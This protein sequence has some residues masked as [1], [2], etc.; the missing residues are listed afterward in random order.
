M[1]FKPAVCPNCNGDL[2]LPEEKDYVKCLYCGTT[3]VV[4]EAIKIA[5]VNIDNNLGNYLTLA[6]NAFHNGHLVDAQYYYTLVLEN[7]INNYEAW[8]GKGDIC[9]NESFKLYQSNFNV[10]AIH[11]VDSYYRKAL[12]NAPVDIMKELKENMSNSIN[13][14]IAT[15]IDIR[16]NYLDNNELEENT[17]MKC[18]LE[19]TFLIANYEIS[20]NLYPST[21][22]AK[23]I[24]DTCNFVLSYD[25]KK[26]Y[27]KYDLTVFGN[28]RKKIFD[29]G[30]DRDVM[31]S[32]IRR[33]K[34]E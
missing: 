9:L 30:K 32:Y 15:I 21:N 20:F 13:K 2:Q 19:I 24:V 1:N 29:L 25:T 34:L 16:K 8:L 10:K 12:E 23:L 18:I 17:L 11:E 31:L 4:Q 14:V 22:T 3:I 27:D 33:Y 28:S 5:I 7:D 26:Y 6:K